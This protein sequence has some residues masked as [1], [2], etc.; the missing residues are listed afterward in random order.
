MRYAVNVAGGACG[1]GR[2]LDVGE[3]LLMFRLGDVV[4]LTD[5]VEEL[6]RDPGR[7]GQRPEHLLRQGGV[8][9]ARPAHAHLPRAP[10]EDGLAAR[11]VP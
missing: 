4:P 3:E 9:A 8:D 2:R 11:L 10:P 7:P 5:G 1:S 6:Q